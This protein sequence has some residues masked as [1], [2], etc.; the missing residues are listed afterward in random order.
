MCVIVYKPKKAV[1]T[2]RILK[3]CWDANP[4]STGFMFAVDGDLTI[5]KGYTVFK[6]FYKDYRKQENLHNENFVLHFRIATHGKINKVN[7]HPF[8]VNKNVG[9]VHN[10]ILHCVDATKDKSDTFVFC[11]QV[12][13]KLPSNF[14]NRKE[15][16]VLL[17]SVCKAESS[18]FV[19][20]T[21]KGIA[22][23]FNEST[24]VWN[25]GCWFSN[26][27]FKDNYELDKN[28]RYEPISNYTH[29]IADDYV[30]CVWCGDYFPA[31]EVADFCEPCCKTCQT[32]LEQDKYIPDYAYKW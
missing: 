27:C 24:G 16:K 17:E 2:K 20:L 8:V 13:R 11:E 31:N 4:D 14:L 22:H 32:E 30:E 5:Q 25:G 12:L 29:N 15:Y 9:F 7:C 21:N 26:I 19:F 6:T 23:I 10:G 28:W 1:I 3:Q 18:K